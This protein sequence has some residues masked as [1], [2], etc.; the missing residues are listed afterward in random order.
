LR[1]I[2]SW[3]RDNVDPLINSRIFRDSGLLLIVFDEACEDGPGADWVF[4]PTVP[5]K[6]GGGRVPPV[7]ISAR[8]PPGTRSSEVYHHEAILRLSLR[9]LGIEQLPG[10]AAG[11]PDMDRF[12]PRVEKRSA[13]SLR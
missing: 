4:D 3:L 7:I 8:T 13:E 1:D 6:R 5:A 2:D 11:T 10:L 9:V 12:F